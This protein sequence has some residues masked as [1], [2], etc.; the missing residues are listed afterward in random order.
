MNRKEVYEKIKANKKALDFAKQEAKRDNLS[1][2]S[3]STG[4]LL[5]ILD[6]YTSNTTVETINKCEDTHPARTRCYETIK[7]NNW[8]DEIKTKYNIPYT[9]LKTEELQKFIVNK[10]KGQ[11]TCKKPDIDGSTKIKTKTE[12]VAAFTAEFTDVKARDAIKAICK[13]FN[14]N[15]ISKMLD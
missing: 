1:W 8:Q 9:N 14:L 3:L 7:N 11:C 10:Q 13:L 2:T 6:I 4:T 15:T 5:S 12:T